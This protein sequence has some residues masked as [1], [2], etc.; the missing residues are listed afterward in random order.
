[1]STTIYGPLKEIDAG[2]V[3]GDKT[4]KAAN[5]ILLRRLEENIRANEAI[6][7]NAQA[8]SAGKTTPGYTGPAGGQPKP[9]SPSQV[10]EATAKNN[11]KEFLGES[12]FPG[13]VKPPGL[14]SSHHAEEAAKT[15][16]ALPGEI[17]GALIGWIKEAIGA[18]FVKAL[19]YVLLAGGGAALIVTGVSR[20]AGL[21]PA[22]AARKAGKL[23][24]AGA[25]A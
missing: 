3:V 7:A 5:A 21:H 4:G 22:Q 14:E 1:M 2:G 23:A 6:I 25:I 24:A 10:A 15:V 18:D 20:A 17:A 12:A 16:S 19:L 11:L 9:L 13:I 8:R